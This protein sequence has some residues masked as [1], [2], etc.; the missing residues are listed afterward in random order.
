MTDRSKGLGSAPTLLA[1]R[2][3]SVHGS[4]ER[5]VRPG[6]L[7]WADGFPLLIEPAVA[8]VELVAWGR[9]NRRFIEEQLVRYG[10]ILFRGFA[11]DSVERFNGFVAAVADEALEYRFRASPRNQVVTGLNIYTSTDYPADQVIFPHNEHAY[12]PTFPLKLF[13]FCIVPPA[14]GGQTPIADNRRVLER[15]PNGIVDRFADKGVLYVRNYNNGFGLSWQSVFQTEKKSV[16]EAYCRE[17]GIRVEWKK[18]GR[19][20]TRQAGPAL[21]R[22]P[23][24]KDRLWFNHATFFHVSTL[25]AELRDGVIASC[26]EENLPTQTFY[27]DGSAI[28]P[29]VLEVLRK[30]YL[31]ELVEF[32][33]KQFDVLLLD[34]MLAVHGRR[35]YR[36]QRQ[37]VAGMAQAGSWL[38]VR[39]QTGLQS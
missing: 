5:W 28:E 32:D 2:R 19:L 34:N 16:V 8:D 30:A 27:G 26:G 29:D 24:T 12:S 6:F 14:S 13:F 31:D 18:G 7:P 1:A 36:G 25:P 4:T 39:F 37:I 10:A 33:W 17:Q 21:V 15:I 20:C 22:H 23:V 3:R 9:D 11:L 35:S 38:D